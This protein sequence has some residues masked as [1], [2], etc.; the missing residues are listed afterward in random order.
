MVEERKVVQYG[1]YYARQTILKEFGRRGQKKLARSK[2]AVVGLGG[3][4]TVSALYLAL[5]G[6]GHLRLID[7]DT[8]ELSN[9][10]RQV[11]YTPDDLHYPKVEVSAERLEKTNPFVKVQP[12]P[13]NLNA[14][15]V[16]KLLS[17][18]DC[19]VDG[20][21]NMHT[22]YLVNRA[23]VKLRLPYVFGAAI[24]LEGNL[25][26]FTSPDTPC[27]ECILPGVEDDFLSTCDVRG[28][29][30]ATAGIIGTM[31][32]MEAVKVLTGIGSVLKGK[33]MICDFSDMYFTTIDIFKRDGCPACQGK[34]AFPETKEKLAWLCG[35]NT[36]NIN[37]GKPLERGF[38]EVCEAVRHN[39]KVRIRSQLAIVFDYKGFEISLFNGGRMLIKN[40]EDEKSALRVYREIRKKLESG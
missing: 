7:Q 28:V 21:D 5:A 12:V 36:V 40:V 38:D 33:L 17:G 4:G 34:K 26:V 30:G 27:L 35:Q 25:S 3:L 24:G 37:P 19:V 11:L 22:R 1:E 8:V 13:E 14:D 29:L 39:F 6:V 2:V 16:E 20:L 23:C 32:A 10:H 15:N 31:Q 18:M 9:L